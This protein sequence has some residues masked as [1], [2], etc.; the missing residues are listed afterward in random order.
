MYPETAQRTHATYRDGLS[1]WTAKAVSTGS[2]PRTLGTTYVRA[3][4]EEHAADLGRDALS[5]RSTLRGRR[6]WTVV[7]RPADPEEDLGMVR[8]TGASTS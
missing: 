6:D 4:D 5:L 7:A 8:L 3:R 2:E 1:S